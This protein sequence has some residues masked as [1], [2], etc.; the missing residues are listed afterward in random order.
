MRCY[1]WTMLVALLTMTSVYADHGRFIPNA[2]AGWTYGNTGPGANPIQFDETVTDTTKSINAGMI[3]FDYDTYFDAPNTGGAGLSGGFFIN[4]GVTLKPGFSLGWVQTVIADH[5][6]T[7]AANRWNLPTEN[8]GEYPDAD[9]KDRPAPGLDP[10]DT[11][12]APTYPY[13][14]PAT[15]PVGMQPTFG[16][17]D[18][19]SRS[20]ADGNQ[21]WLAELGLACIS[22]SANITHDGM[23][24]R[25]VRV[26]DT[27]LWGFNLNGLPAA[28][29]GIGNVGSD[30]PAFWSDPTGSYLDTL[31]DFYDG[32]GGGGAPDPTGG[33]QPG[34]ATDKYRFFNNDNCFRNIPRTDF[35]EDGDSDLDDIDILTNM[36]AAGIQDPLFDLTQDGQIDVA[37]VEDWLLV[38]GTQNLGAPY[39]VGDANLD[40]NVDGQDFLA[41]NNFK[42]GP[43][44]WSGGDFTADGFVDGIDWIQWNN[45]KFQSSFGG[46][47]A[48]P[49]PSSGWLIV[50]SLLLTLSGR[51]RKP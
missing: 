19:P 50:C 25:E 41:W 2:P 27:L 12:L 8:A 4:D 13:N 24:M 21:S 36:V 43:G 48:V 7:G 51:H 11:L 40:G 45:H 9:P 6:G 10:S 28:P 47:F 31:N 34:V 37:D 35:D 29:A 33:V 26:I 15:A 38:A 18:F 49:E 3:R 1:I 23:Q 14:D 22:D 16:F 46:T 42:F 20:T 39:L 32:L 5:T 44:A 17:Q 30:P